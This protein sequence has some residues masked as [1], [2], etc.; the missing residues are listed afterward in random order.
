MNI[1]VGRDPRL[2]EK[3]CSI[4]ASVVNSIKQAESLFGKAT[5]I[6]ASFEKNLRIV[7]IPLLSKEIFIFVITTREMEPKMVAFQISKLLQRFE[8]TA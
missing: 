5:R 6:A 3:Y 4:V 7:I 2:K 1:L 8:S